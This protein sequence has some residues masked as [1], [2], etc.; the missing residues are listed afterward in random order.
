MKDKSLKQ[1]SLMSGFSLLELLVVIALIITLT[2]LYWSAN[3][4]TRRKTMQAACE[5]NLKKIY[6]AMEIFSNDHDL[7][8]PELIGARSSAEALE[9]LVPRYTSDTSIF[10]CP[11]AKIRHRL[12]ANLLRQK[13]SYSYY[14]G[15]RSTDVPSR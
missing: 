11:A 8:F 6:I 10:I 14:M 4:G 15:R 9:T 1:T 7:K 3:S 2:T 5:D 13:I 12:P